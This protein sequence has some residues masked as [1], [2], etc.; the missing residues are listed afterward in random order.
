MEEAVR[1]VGAAPLG[2]L[3]VVLAQVLPHGRGCWR[4]M[5]R[6][7]WNG[8]TQRKPPHP[9]CNRAP[10]GRQAE[11]IP[12]GSRASDTFT[13]QIRAKHLLCARQ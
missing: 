4:A 13:Q 11:R 5:A 7:G 8:G 6:S 9:A 12:G 1:E 10:Q 2:W 3:E